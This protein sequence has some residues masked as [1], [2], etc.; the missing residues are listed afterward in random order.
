MKGK[1]KIGEL[2]VDLKIIEQKNLDAALEEQKRTGERLGAILLR[3]NIIQEEDLEH[4]LS[5]QLHV[6]SIN[7]DNYTPSQDLFKIMPEKIIRKYTVLPVS[8]D[9]RTLTIATANP[10]DLT[11]LDD[12]S[13]VTGY[14]IAPVVTSISALNRKIQEIF[15]QA[16]QWQDALKFDESGYLEIVSP[17]KGVMEE[18]L[19]KVFKQAEETVVVKLVNAIIME[20]IDKE[21]THIHIEPKEEAFEIYLRINGRLKLLI[22]PPL[23]LQQNVLNRIKILS[24][25]DIISKMVPLEGYF[26]AKLFGKLFDIDV[27]TIPSLHGE[28][29]VLT[30]QQPFSKEEL[31]LEKLGFAPDTLGSFK[32]LLQNPRGLILVTGQSD[33]G[34]SSTIYAALNHLKNPDKA[35]FTYERTIKNKLSGITQGQPNEKAGYSYENGLKALNRQ[36]MDVLMVG[37]MMT[38]ETIVSALL[39][40]MPKTLVLSRFLSNDTIGAVSMILDMDVPPFML[41]SALTAILGQRLV[42]RL[43]QECI[44][45]YDPPRELAEEIQS[46]TGNISP[47]LFRSR[48]CMACGHSGYINRIGLFEL[49]IPST[50]FR[51]AIFARAPLSELKTAAAKIG[52][53]TFR[54]DGLMKAAEGLTSFEELA[55]VI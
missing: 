19:E 5:R 38:K 16:I 11:L 41:Y 23:N 29:M 2:L 24:S 47:R 22:K 17:E 6:P 50:E 32:E 42:R 46:L 45:D 3:M 8:V 43:C 27:A 14:K 51:D 40:S 4:I 31:K 26:R 28:R 13:R 39:T 33:S 9:R 21:A 54:Q 12:L 1:H 18:D 25:I 34:K 10:R 55:R 7:L 49:I 37:E 15:D 48:G 30:F 36:D 35:V 20:A 52:Y 53:R 44:T